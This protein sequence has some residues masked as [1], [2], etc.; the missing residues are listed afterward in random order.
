VLHD[1]PAAPGGH[2]FTWDGRGADGSLL[3]DGVYFYRVRAAG[4]TLSRKVIL[5]RSP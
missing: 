4:Q 5:L 3:A 2:G 1:G